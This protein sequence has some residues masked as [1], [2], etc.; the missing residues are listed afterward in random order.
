MDVCTYALLRDLGL[1]LISPNVRQAIGV[2][3]D[4]IR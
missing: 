4:K 3:F 1:T 2:D